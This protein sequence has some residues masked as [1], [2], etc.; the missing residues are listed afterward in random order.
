MEGF[1]K[2]TVDEGMTVECRLKHV[3]KFDKMLLLKGFTQAL[4]MDQDEIIEAMIVTSVAD[5]ISKG[6]AEK[7]D[8]DDSDSD[9]ADP[10]WGVG[11]GCKASEPKIT[12]AEF[13]LGAIEKLYG[14][15]K[16]QQEDS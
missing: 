9:E 15:K 12:Q 1:I 7:L 10:N 14:K 4:K 13:D 5:K 3:G 16:D 11:W 8:N 6:L 2:I